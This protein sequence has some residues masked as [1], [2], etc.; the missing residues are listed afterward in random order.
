MYYVAKLNGGLRLLRE[1]SEQLAAARYHVYSA[2]DF[3]RGEKL[4]LW[5]GRY[6][7]VDTKT[8]DDC[9]AVLPGISK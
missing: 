3:A 1:H 5:P 2:A 9:A 6:D 8:D 4:C 7:A